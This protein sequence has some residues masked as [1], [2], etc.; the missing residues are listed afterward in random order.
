MDTS[1]TNTFTVDT[2]IWDSGF[3]CDSYIEFLQELLA[4]G[5]TT[6]PN[7]SAEML[8]YAKVNLARMKRVSTQFQVDPQLLE[9]LHGKP[10]AWKFIIMAEGWCGDAAQ[11]VPAIC[12]MLDSR[13]WPY[14]I[15]LRDENSELMNQFLTNGTRSI[16]VVA[17]FNA[18]NQQIGT[19]WGPR[20]IE[21]QE[22]VDQWKTEMEKAD[23]HKLLH[24]WY[25][26]DKSQT[27]QRD[28]AAWI[29][30]L[31]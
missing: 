23:W 2:T 14:K 21:L 20:P 5:K 22:L 25:A 30:T 15:F 7:Q 28:F 6:G 16:P 17:A 4:H 12:R 10:S 26:K 19:H 13:G 9:T 31:G 8:E 11:M 24:A 27:L 3:S 18:E 1:M 29:Q